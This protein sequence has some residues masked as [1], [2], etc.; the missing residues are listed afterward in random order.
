MNRYRNDLV[1][2][3]L[4]GTLALFALSGCWTAIVYE[5]ASTE[6]E[7][8]LAQAVGDSAAVEKKGDTLRILTPDERVA[9]V[10]VTD[11]RKFKVVV[12][13]ESTQDVT[14]RTE[15]LSWLA[16]ANESCALKWERKTVKAVDPVSLPKSEVGQPSHIGRSKEVKSCDTLKRCLRTLAKTTC[17]DNPDCGFDI[18]ANPFEES[19]CKTILDAMR[20][21]SNDTSEALPR[22]CF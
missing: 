19:I 17:R 3:I 12:R 14:F 20:R 16:L 11:E 18:K 5:P 2:R 8:C 9:F 13:E 22:E 21:R 4:L 7:N 10:T 1:A 6:P 15:V